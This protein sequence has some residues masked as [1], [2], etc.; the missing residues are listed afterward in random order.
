MSKLNCH[1]SDYKKVT[2]TFRESGGWFGIGAKSTV[3]VSGPG[4]CTGT[5]D[6]ARLLTLNNYRLLVGNFTNQGKIECRNPRS[7]PACT[8]R[9]NSQATKTYVCLPDIKNY[10]EFGW[11]NNIQ[12]QIGHR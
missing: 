1:L 5:Y 6:H 2:L 3:T 9:C 12:Y 4:A 7:T 8:P 10:G 11:K